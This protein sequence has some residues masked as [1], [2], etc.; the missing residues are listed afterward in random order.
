[1]AATK[2]VRGL[3]AQTFFT[4]WLAFVDIYI[5]IYIYIYRERERERETDRERERESNVLRP[6]KIYCA[7]LNMKNG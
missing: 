1:M 3:S 5:Y 2:Q 4:F 6:R 7:H